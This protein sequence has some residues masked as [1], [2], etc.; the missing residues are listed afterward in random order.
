MRDRMKRN[1]LTTLMFSQGVRMLLGGDENGRTQLGNNN[2]YCQD[3]EIG[4]VNWDIDEGGEALCDFT[5]ELISIVG[6]TPFCAGAT[7]S[8]ASPSRA[9]RRM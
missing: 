6:R 9:T 8:A 2:A 1:F 5:A 7:S 3:N 4:W